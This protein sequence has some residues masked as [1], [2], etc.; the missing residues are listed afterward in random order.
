MVLPVSTKCACITDLV[1]MQI[2][3][4]QICNAIVYESFA[5]VFESN[6]IV[7]DSYPIVYMHILQQ[8]SSYLLF[9]N[10]IKQTKTFVVFS[11]RLYNVQHPCLLKLW[12]LVTS[13]PM[14]IILLLYQ[15]YNYY[16]NYIINYSVFYF[17]GHD[18]GISLEYNFMF[19]INALF[20]AIQ[21]FR[22]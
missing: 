14:S 9:A 11:C 18:Y 22:K 10:W 3:C 19:M 4:N 2:F 21:N 16:G 5:I 20:F 8:K 7:Y 1:G 13:F 17:K 12:C 6:V 15:V